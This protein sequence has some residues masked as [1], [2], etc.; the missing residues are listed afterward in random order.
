[1]PM[2]RKLGCRI[3]WLGCMN[4]LHKQ[5]RRLLGLYGDWADAYVCQSDYQ[6]EVLTRQ[7]GQIT[8]TD[9]NR[10]HLIRGAFDLGQFPYRP[11]LRNSDEPLVWGRLARPDGDKWPPDL[12]RLGQRL[13]AYAQRARVMAWTP[14]LINVCGIPPAWAETLAPMQ[15]PAAQFVQSLHALLCFAAPQTVENWPRVGLEAMASG[16]P[17]IAERR[18]GWCE[19]IKHGETGLLAD[20]IDEAAELLAELWHDEALRVRLSRNAV[21]AVM[22]WADPAAFLDGWEAVLNSM[23]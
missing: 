1:V 10:W 7:A 15:E 2:L 23:R 5:E 6:R 14:A 4:W 12:W 19:M 20:S 3:V 21:D 9:L 16:T 17:I 13:P 22:R 18:G 11:K 8:Q